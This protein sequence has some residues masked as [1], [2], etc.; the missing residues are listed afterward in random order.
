[1]F[2]VPTGR[3]VQDLDLK[4]PNG[5]AIVFK[6]I[7]SASCVMAVSGQSFGAFLP[8]GVTMVLSGDSNDYFG[9]GLSG[10]KL[11]AFS[12][13][14]SRFQPEENIIIGNVTL[15]GATS[16]KAFINGIAGERFCP[17]IPV[18]LP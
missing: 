2:P 9:K 17:S 7:P 8:K 10:G 15:Y 5:L 13:K 12:S 14:E 6:K 1:M 11:V 3:L 16:G 4:Q 18:P